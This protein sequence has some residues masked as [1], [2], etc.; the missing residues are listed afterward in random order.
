MEKKALQKQYK[1]KTPISAIDAL[2]FEL[3]CKTINR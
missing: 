1:H 2:N 3:T